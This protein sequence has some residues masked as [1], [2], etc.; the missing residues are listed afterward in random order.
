MCFIANA[1]KSGHF[2]ICIRPVISFVFLLFAGG[3][4]GY[5]P[6]VRQGRSRG[7]RG[8]APWKILKLSL[9]VCECNFHIW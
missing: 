8:Y 1:L 7:K 2:V 9:S 6:N 5:H 3:G 4:G